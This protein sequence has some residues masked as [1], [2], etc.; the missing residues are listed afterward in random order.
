MSLLSAERCHLCLIIIMVMVMV[1]V[2]IA[3]DIIGIVVIG[4]VV[5]GIVIIA[6]VF[7]TIP[8][9]GLGVLT[10]CLHCQKCMTLKSKG[11]L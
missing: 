7:C 6:I 9:P 8:A 4:I 5:I 2:V 11:K 1:I 10:V 3:I